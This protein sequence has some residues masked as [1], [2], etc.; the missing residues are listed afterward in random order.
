MKQLRYFVVLVFL[1]PIIVYPQDQPSKFQVDYNEIHGQLT[2]KDLVKKDF[3]RYKGFE[4]EL[5]AG[6]EV[7]FLVYSNDFQPVL[8]LVNPKG[9]IV[10]Q[11]TNDGKGYASILTNISSS[12]NWILYIVSPQNTKGKYVLRNSIA[13]P[14][15]LELANGSDFCTTL[16]FILAHAK[17]YFVLM[18][19]SINSNQKM[20]KLNESIDQFFDENDGSYNALYYNGDKFEEAE[21]AFSK[22]SSQIEGCLGNDWTTLSTNWSKV[23][24]FKEKSLTL[25]EKGVDKPRYITIA[26]YDFQGSTRRLTNRFNV[27]VQ[28]NKKQ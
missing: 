18:E 28:I 2:S 1:I 5:Y 26:A 21:A 12:G 9:E 22:L 3:G 20:V 27:E 14:N 25:T 17:A 6:E 24:D 13:E 15:S 11:S 19:N 23:D 7:N 8:A 4:I 10:N 16:D